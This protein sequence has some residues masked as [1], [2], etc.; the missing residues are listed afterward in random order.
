MGFSGI[1]NVLSA[2]KAAKYYEMDSNDI[3]VT[4]LTDSMDLYQLAAA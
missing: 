3:M 1:S 4:V 2:I